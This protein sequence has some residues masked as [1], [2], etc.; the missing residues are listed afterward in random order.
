MLTNTHNTIFSLSFPSL[1][2]LGII[3]RKLFVFYKLN[4]F[5]LLSIRID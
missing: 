3:I 5:D 1:A 2:S 4:N